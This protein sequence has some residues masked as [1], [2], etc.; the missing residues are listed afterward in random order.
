MRAIA[1]DG[2]GGPETLKLVELPDPEPGPGQVLIAVAFAGVNPVDWKIREGL[3]VDR[4]P[5]AFPLIPGWECSG[6][7]AAVGEGVDDFTVGDEVYTYCRKKVVQW[8]TDC[9]LVAVDAD[10]VARKPG[11]LDTPQAAAVPLAALTA[12]QSL[13]DHAKLQAGETVLVHAAAGG[14]GSFAV[15]IAHDH[16]AH[17]IGTASEANHGY[18]REMGCEQ[19]IDYRTTDFVE[20]VK[21]VH[22]EGVDVVFDLVGG[23]TQARSLDALADGGR[24]VSIVEP[25]QGEA[26][27]RRHIAGQ[28][29]FV[30]PNGWQLAE[31][32]AMFDEGALEVAVQQVFPLEEAAA[33]QELS[34]AGHVRGK[35][36]L[37]VG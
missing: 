33:A 15:Q 16:G 2:F 3:L 26:Y 7:V 31:I 11:V 22:H 34:R 13:I 23:E 5:H 37:Q 4:L 29:V 35:L 9:E 1:I 25:P 18:V 19:V 12:W 36:V 28:Y 21:A 17:V 14:V 8:G 27:R 24:L 30:Q 32:G 6:T 20:A 10:D